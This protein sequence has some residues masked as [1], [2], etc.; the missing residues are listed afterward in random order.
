MLDNPQVVAVDKQ[1]S[2]ADTV[3]HTVYPVEQKRK[4]EL[5]SELIGKQNWQQVLVFASTRESC[6]EL[7]EE[8]NLDG[9]KSAVVHGDKARG[10]GRR[11][12]REFTEGKLLGAGGHRG[13]QSRW[14]PAFPACE[15]DLWCRATIDLAAQRSSALILP[16]GATAD[17]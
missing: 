14:P 11:A 16:R 5:L 4:R 8:L 17:S 12:L 9:I 15:L 10:A 2:T 1:N 13:L 3:S 7:V 6:D